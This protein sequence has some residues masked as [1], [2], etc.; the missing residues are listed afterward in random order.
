M[1]IAA[2]S[3][4]CV[5]NQD[6]MKKIFHDPLLHF[7][8]IGTALFLIFE[9]FSTP[10]DT[11]ENQIVITNGDV[12]SIQATFTKTWQ[13]PP[14]EQELTG[15]IEEKVK[16]EIAYRE[17]TAMGLDQEDAYIRRRLRMKLELL[18]EDIAGLAPPTDK[19]LSAYLEQNIDSFRQAPQVSF[20]HVFINS[21]KR[22][23]ASS[24]YARQTLKQLF[25]IGAEADLQKF[26]DPIL[27]P[28]ELPLTSAPNISRQF[29]DSFLREL[30]SCDTAKWSGP[31][32]SSYG[33]HLVFIR[34]RIKGRTPELTEVRDAVE[35]EWTARRR[36][37]FKEQTYKKLRDRYTIRIEP[38]STS[39]A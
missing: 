6:I 38:R 1:C 16:E 29:G 10:S 7:L 35:R 22:G 21:G 30:L 36:S 11:L 13:R 9:L 17:A 31:I 2:Y 33:L 24:D 27:L 37:E 23:D 32:I 34:K 39:D 19:E 28:G 4:S 26:G 15:L 20:Q 8:F 25:E 12:E 18:V 5:F 3:S 14:T